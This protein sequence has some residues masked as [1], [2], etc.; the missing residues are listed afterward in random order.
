MVLIIGGHQRSGTT[1]LGRLC[2]S[3][4][5]IAVT[6]ELGTF[7][8]CGESR[9]AYCRRMM[10]RWWDVRNRWAFDSSYAGSPGKNSRN[11]LFVSRYLINVLRYSQDVVDVHAIEAALRSMFPGSRVVGDKWPYYLNVMD[12][13]IGMDNLG[14]LIVYRDC[15]DVVSSTL[16]KARGSW[17][18][19][20]FG[21]KVNT[22]EKVAKRWVNA[23]ELM[24]SLKESAHIIRYE[25]LVR[26]PDREL[27]ALGE[28]LGVVPQ[29]FARHMIRDSSIGKHKNGLTEEELG[30]VMEIAGPTMSRLSYC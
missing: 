2:D 12:R 27:E 29:G 15:R 8:A 3:H 5:E 7:I 20:P 26:E 14:V 16:E 13:W 9:L 24:E 21:E 28:W 18:G 30:T 23:I 22:A 10:G 6:N 17:S 1:L 11:L 19:M 4:P 25:D